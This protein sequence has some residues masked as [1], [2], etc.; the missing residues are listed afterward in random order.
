MDEKS[1]FG[2]LSSEEEVQEI[3]DDAVSITT[4]QATKFGWDYLT[5]HI[6]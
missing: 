6:S 3:V 1:S 2:E 5:L 4:Q